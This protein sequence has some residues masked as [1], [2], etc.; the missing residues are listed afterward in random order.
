MIAENYK[1]ILKKIEIAK[2]RRRRVSKGNDV[3]LVAV[4][5]NHDIS[6]MREAIDAGATQIGENR[7]QEAKDKF[8][9]L[10]RNVTWHLIGH[11]QTN[12]V[13]LAV[14]MFDFIHSVD[15]FKLAKAINDAAKDIDKVQEILVQVNLAKEEQKF[16]VYKEDLLPLVKEID[17]MENLK[18]RGI[19]LI[20]PNFTDKEL[21]RPLFREM[22]DIFM[23][24]QTRALIRADINILSMGMTGDFETAV[25]E[26]STLVRVGT[27]IFGMRNYNI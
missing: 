23:D 6:A 19:M 18:L 16:G 20:A 10:E 9:T 3:T 17:V 8:E 22:Y 13:R 12:K 4:T 21:A 2:E 26:G 27:G 11:L 14:K 25:E 15:S 1:N 5:K 24:L 7:V